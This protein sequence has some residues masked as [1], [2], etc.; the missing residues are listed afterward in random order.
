[1]KYYL[2][3]LFYMMMLLVLTGCAGVP[4]P[5]EVTAETIDTVSQISNVITNNIEPWVLGVIILLAGWAI[6]SPMEMIRGLFG[7][8]GGVVK[9]FRG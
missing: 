2:L 1:M 3:V 6:P 7:F 8:V 5:Q 4:A 9:L